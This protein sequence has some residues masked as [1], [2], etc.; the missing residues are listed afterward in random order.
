MG[1]FTILL[2]GDI[3]ASQRLLTQIQH[4]QIIAADG[5]IRHADLLGC[6]PTIWI[7]DF[8]STDASLA[9][10]HQAVKRL[11]YPV[12]KDSTDG[13]LAIDA[14]L[15]AGAREIILCGAFG[16][17]SDQVLLHMTMAAALAEQN[18]TC[19]LT[20]GVEEGYP[21]LSGQHRFSLPTGSLFSLIAFEAITGLTIKGA[22]W[23]GQWPGLDF[24][25]SLCLS[26]V[27]VP[28][29]TAD[30]LHH[31]LEISMTAGKGIVIA[32]L[33]QEGRAWQD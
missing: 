13:A 18:I 19:W 17:R 9:H 16:G 4:T 14:A 24:G 1:R 27:V 11:S 28:S 8:D 25:S 7:G 3:V 12:K 29:S 10:R 22:E 26:N 20:N 5:G 30:G 15:Q 2:N 33:P 21:V 32:T 23:S 6:E 31:T